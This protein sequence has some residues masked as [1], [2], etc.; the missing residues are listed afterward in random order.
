M[1]LASSNR[2]KNPVEMNSPHL[3]K[4]KIVWELACYKPML[5]GIS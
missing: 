3:R 1:E 2:R 4:Q 5:D